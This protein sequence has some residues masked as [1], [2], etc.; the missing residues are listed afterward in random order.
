MMT[1]TRKD[2]AFSRF[3]AKLQDVTPSQQPEGL[4]SNDELRMEIAEMSAWQAVVTKFK[5]EADKY[6]KTDLKM[7]ADMDAAA[8]KYQALVGA[9]IR[10]F[11][12]NVDR[13]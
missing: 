1:A 12:E 10:Q 4:Y 8:A 2:P 9:L 3:I 6:R 7:A 11:N 5:A 13:I